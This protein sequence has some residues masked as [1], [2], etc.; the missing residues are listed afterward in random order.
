MG[1]A[2]EQA[3][4]PHP[5]GMEKFIEKIMKLLFHIIKKMNI[6]MSIYTIYCS[7]IL[8][9]VLSIVS[10]HTYTYSIYIPIHTAYIYI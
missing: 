2:G 10:I 4:L 7:V 1:R 6:Y 3:Y 9:I 5:P 8:S